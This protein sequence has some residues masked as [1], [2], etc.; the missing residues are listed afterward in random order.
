MSHETSTTLTAVSES[1]TVFS[2]CVLLYNEPQPQGR[3][4]HLQKQHTG[5]E[6]RPL[7]AYKGAAQT[8]THS[9]FPGLTKHQWATA[10]HP[11]HL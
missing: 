11:F 8:G 2:C 6:Q 7:Q 1:D 4:H 9:S 5:A 3:S 10:V